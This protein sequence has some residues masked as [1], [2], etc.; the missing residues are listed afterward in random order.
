MAALSGLTHA[1]NSE[2]KQTF[3]VANPKSLDYK[4]VGK[5]DEHRFGVELKENKQFHHT[6]TGLINETAEPFA[7]KLFYYLNQL[8]TGC[9]SAVMDMSWKARNIRRIMWLMARVIDW[10]RITDSSLFTLKTEVKR[11]K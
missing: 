10:Y 6:K 2:S 11:G 3:F 4:F 1:A 7:G 9:D 5:K 8:K